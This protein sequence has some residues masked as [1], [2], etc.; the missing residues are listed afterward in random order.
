MRSSGKRALFVSSHCRFAWKPFPLYVWRKWT[1]GGKNTPTNPRQVSPHCIF[2]IKYFGC[3]GF[4]V[5]RRWFFSLKSHPTLRSMHARAKILYFTILLRLNITITSFFE[6]HLGHLMAEIQL[7]YLIGWQKKW[8]SLL[9]PHFKM[10]RVVGLLKADMLGDG[11]TWWSSNHREPIICFQCC[12]DRVSHLF[13][14]LQNWPFS[15]FF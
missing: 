6:E 2:F 8:V 14:V 11:R 5:L 9:T 7:V 3:S 1:S 13:A 12:N 15:Q 10:F 4:Q